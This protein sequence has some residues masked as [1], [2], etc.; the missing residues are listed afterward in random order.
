MFNGGDGRSTAGKRAS[1][2]RPL[3]ELPLSVLDGRRSGR[4]N[5]ASFRRLS[6]SPVFGRVR[7]VK[8]DAF[9][10]LSSGLSRRVL[11]NC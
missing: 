1:R 10:M 8:I 9:A 4:E 6:L 5:R 7:F 3:V 11:I 2:A